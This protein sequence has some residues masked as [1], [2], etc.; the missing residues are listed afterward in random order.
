MGTLLFLLS[1]WSA[2]GRSMYLQG[3][4]NITPNRG[5]LR[6]VDI[7]PPY[8]GTE[9]SCGKSAVKELLGPF[10]PIRRSWQSEPIIVGGVEAKRNA[11]PWMAL[12]GVEEGRGEYNWFCAGALI[13][14]QWIL[15]AAHCLDEITPRIVRLGEHDYNDDLDQ[16]A[17]EDFAIEKQIS[18]PEYTFPMAYHDL[19]L[20]KLAKKVTIKEFVSPVCLPWQEESRTDLTG[21]RVKVTGWGDTRDFGNPS[22]ILQEVDVTVFPTSECEN[23][24]RKLRQFRLTWPNGIGEETT[25]AGDRAGGR[26]ACQ[27]DSGGPS[28]Y[29]SK[30]KWIVKGVVSKGYGCGSQLYPGLYANV[31]YPPHLAWIKKVAF[32]NN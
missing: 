30:G 5:S 13:N 4:G 19:A 25:C 14:D 26:D 24:Y 11:W 29:Y 3:P 27:G 23:K 17:H 9:L 12:L 8:V 1:L 18:Y 16:A 7:S 21:R 32:E 15:T 22:S 20:L 28:I 10:I 31:Q 6:T 2:V